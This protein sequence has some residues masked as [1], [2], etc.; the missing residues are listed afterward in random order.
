MKLFEVGRILSTHGLAGEVKVSVITDFPDQRFSP[1]SKLFCEKGR[2]ELTLKSGQPFKQ[3]WLVQ[4]EE[5]TDIDEAK[6]LQ[7]QMLLVSSDDQQDL[8]AGSYYYHDILGCS[9]FEDG[10]EIGKVTDIEQPGANDIWEVTDT[11]G[12]NFWLPYIPS[13]VKK[14]DIE[15]KHI[16]VE[17]ME[18]LRDEY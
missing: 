4:F 14:V 15:E 5:V 1:G 12:K 7:G 9:V 17:L 18:G 8:P 10:Q 11:H 13:V 16:D 6:S 3:F 2:R